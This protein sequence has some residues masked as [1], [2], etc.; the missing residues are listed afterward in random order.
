MGAVAEGARDTLPMGLILFPKFVRALVTG[1]AFRGAVGRVTDEDEDEIDG[2]KYPCHH[3]ADRPC[4][5]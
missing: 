3:H 4:F 5:L 2:K 1:L